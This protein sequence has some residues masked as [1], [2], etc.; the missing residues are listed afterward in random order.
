MDD[1][2]SN[3]LRWWQRLFRFRVPDPAPLPKGEGDREVVGEGR[4]GGVENPPFWGVSRGASRELTPRC[5]GGT[6]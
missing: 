5:C 3:G 6:K 1:E 4:R 2:P